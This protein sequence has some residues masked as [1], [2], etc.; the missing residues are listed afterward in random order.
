MELTSEGDSE[1][2]QVENKAQQAQTSSIEACAENHWKNIP[3]LPNHEAIIMP[4][5]PMT[6][7]RAKR[8]QKGLNSCFQTKFSA[9]DK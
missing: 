7:A 1:I 2:L 9:N 8:L 4:Q 3:S 6:R 5:G